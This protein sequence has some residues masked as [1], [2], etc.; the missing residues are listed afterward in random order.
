MRKTLAVLLVLCGLAVALYPLA[1]SLYRDYRTAQHLQAF[2]EMREKDES[3]LPLTEEVPEPRDESREAE[4][5]QHQEEEQ[6]EQE[7]KEEERHKGP[8]PIAVLEIDKIGLKLPVLKGTSDYTLS[9][10]AGLMEEMAGIGEAGNT[11][12]TA[13]RAHAYGRLFNRLDELE[14]G[15]R[16]VITTTNNS[17]SYRVFNT[18]IVEA[19]DNSY[20]SNDQEVQHLTLITCHPLFKRNPSYRLV[21]QANLE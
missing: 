5:E 10:G 7:E 14:F 20:L 2:E 13:H 17:F 21:V 1:Q 19:G 16:I 8:P 6:E 9:F 3:A 15:D 4:E 11:V 18:D 12:I